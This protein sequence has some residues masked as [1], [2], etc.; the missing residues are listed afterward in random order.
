MHEIILVNLTG[1]DKPGLTRDITKV[2]ETHGVDVMDIGLA[3]IHDHVSMALLIRVE[4]S[5]VS[6]QV[7]KDLLFKAHERSLNISFT[8]M[9]DESYTDWVAQQTQER[10]VVTMLARQITA[11]HIARLTGIVLEQ[12]LNVEKINRISQRP[13]LTPGEEPGR[14]CI[15]INVLGS[16][17]NAHTMRAELMFMAQEEG[18]DISLQ[19]DNLFRRNRRLV[20]MDMD[21]TLIQQEVINE[22]AIEAGVGDQVAAITEAAMRGELDFRASFE[23]RVGLLKG[24]PEAKVNAVMD[25]I[26]LS[27]GAE[28]LVSTLKRLGYKTAILSGGFTL[29]G[30][31]LQQMLGIDYVY[32]N[33]LEFRDGALSGRVIE[34][35]VDGQRK[36]ELLKE[37]AQREGLDLQQVVAIGDGANDLPMLDLAGLGIAFRAKPLVKQRADH[38]ISVLGLDGVLYLMGLR[39]RE[40]RE[41]AGG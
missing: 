28:R 3:V 31:M 13:S 26:Q 23:Q 19:A 10:H 36:A 16:P 25:R 39:D 33:Q 40:L 30:E 17:K 4:R 8:P 2:L 27:E 11:Q 22:L 29:F 24:L 15:S 14:A 1:A 38:S 6:Y 34:P 35:I 20:V 5:E 41:G 9:T 32:A 18:V 37:L 12:G 21:S 7:L